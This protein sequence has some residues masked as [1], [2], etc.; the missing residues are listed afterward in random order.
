MPVRDAEG[1]I[2]KD[3]NGKVETTDVDIDVTATVRNGQNKV[4]LFG[5]CKFTSKR[6]GFESLNRLK[7]RVRLLKGSYN[8]RLAL[9]SVSGFEAD[10]EEYAEDNGILLFGLD[11]L[12][13]KAPLP[14][15]Q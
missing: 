4:D 2:V 8:V 6:M 3:I 9:F 7:E 10:L 12:I 14:P 11:T 13:G 1:R 5:E 15:I